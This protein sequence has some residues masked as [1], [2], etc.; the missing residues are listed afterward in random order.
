MSSDLATAGDSSSRT[1]ELGLL[2]FTS[3]PSLTS[4][5]AVLPEFA[6]AGDSSSTLG[7][8]SSSSSAPKATPSVSSLLGGRALLSAP[9]PTSSIPPSSIS[10]PPRIPAV[11]TAATAGDVSLRSEELLA[12][13][14]S[15][16]LDPSSSSSRV[17]ISLA[18]RMGAPPCA[19][20]LVS[21]PAVSSFP[22]CSICIRAWT[23]PISSLT[24]SVQPS[25][26][27]EGVL[28]TR[29]RQRDSLGARHSSSAPHDY[30]TAK[31]PSK[32]GRKEGNIR[33]HVRCI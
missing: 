28:W 23:W 29:F 9:T 26:Y 19:A 30:L 22:P 1:D 5:S 14:S 8:G 31:S 24:E 4:F 13:S 12:R 27:L 18:V 6:A 21:S 17:L 32:E 11:A 2:S 7:E 25:R 20:W 3:P 10:S 15:S 16:P 33:R